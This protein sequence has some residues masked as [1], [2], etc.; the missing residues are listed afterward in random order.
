MVTIS[1]IASSS[2]KR[3]TV[4]WN[5]AYYSCTGYEVMWSTTSN[6][7]SNFLSVYVKGQGTT[8]TTLKTSQSGKYYYVRIRPY[9]ESNGKKTY[10]SWSAVKKIKVKEVTKKFSTTHV[11]NFFV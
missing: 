9:K 4:K 8:S 3:I 2:T 1:S 5:K 11:L 6:F 7:S 10:C